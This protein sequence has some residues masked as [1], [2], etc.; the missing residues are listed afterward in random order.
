MTGQQEKGSGITA[1]KQVATAVDEAQLQGRDG[2]HVET[3]L[4]SLCLRHQG[5]TG[6]IC[7]TI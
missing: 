5:F 1:A 6:R 2:L 7:E 4:P 3:G